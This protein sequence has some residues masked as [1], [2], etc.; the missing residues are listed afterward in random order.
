[1]RIRGAVIDAIIAHARADAPRECCGLLLGVEAIVEA[2][3]PAANV[4]PGEVTFQIDPADHFAAIRRARAERRAVVGAYH[5]H[6]ASPAV[7]SA[8]DVQEANDPTLLH[9]I[10]SLAETPPRVAAYRIEDGTVTPVTLVVDR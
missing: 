8:T 6:P 5:S 4:R 2:A 7:P 3:H 1:V 10:V 9:V